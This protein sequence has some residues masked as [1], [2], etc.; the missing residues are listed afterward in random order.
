VAQGTAS[1]TEWLVSFAELT[2]TF[3]IA[4]TD[5]TYGAADA[6][7]VRRGSTT[8]TITNLT[9]DTVPYPLVT[10][11]ASAGVADHPSWSDCPIVHGAAD[12]IVCVA[13]PLAA[14]ASR[15]LA[16]PF[17]ADLPVMDFR[18]SVRLDAGADV[19]GTV[20]DGTAAGTTYQV[21]SE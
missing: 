19:D 8:V 2:G 5:L 12:R 14:G 3:D 20:I 18:A 15:E 7:G 9:G 6:N 4:A 10:F 17:V 16:F 11:P 1:S 21:S 13:E